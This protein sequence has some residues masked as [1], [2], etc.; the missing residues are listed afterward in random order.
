MGHGDTDH[1]PTDVAF[2]PDGRH[3]ASGC[4]YDNTIKLWDTQTG[5]CLGTIE[6]DEPFVIRSVAFSPDGKRLAS[7]VSKRITLWDTETWKCARTL[8]E[9]HGASSVCFS[10]DGKYLVSDTCW[11]D[12]TIRLFDSQT[13]SC[14]GTLQ[15]GEYCVFSPNGQYLAVLQRYAIHLWDTLT[16]EQLWTIEAHKAVDDFSP[17]AF[18]PDGKRLASGGVDNILRLWDVEAGECLLSVELNLRSL[19]SLAFSPD[20][21]YLLLGHYSDPSVLL[22]LDSETGQPLKSIALPQWSSVRSVAFS[23]DGRF[24]AVC[25]REGNKPVA[26]VWEMRNW[27]YRGHLQGQE[28]EYNF[29]AIA[30]SPDG[31]CLAC[32]SDIGTVTLWNIMTNEHSHPA[33]S[34][35]EGRVRCLAFSPDG[36]ELVSGGAYQLRFW[37]A[38]TG[39]PLREDIAG[40]GEIYSVA[41]SLDGMHLF[42]SDRRMIAVFSTQTWQR[43]REQET[44]MSSWNSSFSPDL[45]TLVER[46][47][48]NLL[49]CDTQTGKCYRMIRDIAALLIQGVDLRKVQFS[50]DFTKERKDIL[51]QYGAI[52]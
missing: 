6:E 35:R 38:K 49:F 17:I 45:G 41:F 29:S 28:K 48:C 18:S 43:I 2:T 36:K 5:H 24:F 20:G 40:F 34:P 26:R 44:T 12:D 22:L 21:R 25:G 8:E 33:I 10:P 1:L 42:C 15:G 16:W 32:G 30:F 39:E 47:K 46:N 9:P 50:D 31:Q 27:I 7:G 14:L 51:R 13:G 52:L 23:P 37:N 4:W 3:L 19:T 11:G